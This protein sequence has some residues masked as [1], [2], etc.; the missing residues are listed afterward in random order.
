MDLASLR[1]FKT[2][3]EQGGI[4]RAAAKLHRVPSN[5]T[6]RVKQL[7]QALG[8]RLFTRAGRQ[9]ALSPQGKLLLGYA[10]QLLRLSDEAQTMLR[11]GKP[12]GTLRIGALESTSGSRLP[13][14]LS[15][16][17]LAYPE[18]QLELVTGT[19]GALVSR[20]HKQEIEA[21]FVAE[22]FNADGLEAMPAFLEELV[23]IAPRGSP[24]L[25]SPRD[26]AG[27]TVI[28]FA[29]GCSYRRRL[30]TWLGGAKVPTTRV[31]EFQSY[32]AIVA[33][34][35]AGTGIAVVPRSVIHMALGEKDVAI[36]PLPRQ[37]A[38]AH[39][40]LVWAAGHHSAAL[41]AMKTLLATKAAPSPRGRR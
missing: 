34:V 26:I 41:Q 38:Q 19:S 5:V 21:A 18:V 40:R 11:D 6:T 30:E 20:L 14:L 39:T 8:A 1:I 32:H 13:P 3:V 15:R 17:H 12:H 35:A 9:L 2:V 24:R 37:I 36:A 22:P 16:Y 23:L 31:M 4:T 10:E 29:A 27:R 25:R 33:C 28:A 7:E